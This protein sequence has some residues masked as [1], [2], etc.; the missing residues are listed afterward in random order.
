MRMGALRNNKFVKRFWTRWRKTMHH[1][2]SSGAM[3]AS[4][5]QLLPRESVHSLP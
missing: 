2:Y 3:C 4:I 1:A 5:I